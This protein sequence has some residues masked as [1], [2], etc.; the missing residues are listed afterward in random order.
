[1]KRARREY[2]S[3]IKGAKLEVMHGAFGRR[4]TLEMF[5]DSG[6]LLKTIQ[7]SRA[8]TVAERL[9]CNVVRTDVRKMKTQELYKEDFRSLC[10]CQKLKWLWYW[11]TWRAV[12]K[13]GS[14]FGCYWWCGGRRTDGDPTVCGDCGRVFRVRDLVHSYQ[15]DGCGDVEGVD[16]C[17][18]CGSESV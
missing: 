9:N 11:W 3:A 18:N 5:D 2:I 12:I 14:W 1:M 6:S 4:T 8:M 10:L 17:P 13:V 16:E 15:S 7:G